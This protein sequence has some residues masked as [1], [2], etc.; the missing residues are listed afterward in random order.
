MK[1]QKS[2][3]G[4]RNY[5]TVAILTALNKLKL[6]SPSLNPYQTWYQKDKILDDPQN[7]LETGDK[8]NRCKSHPREL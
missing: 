5:T 6:Q 2:N 1:N 7:Y 3:K 4:K 8:L